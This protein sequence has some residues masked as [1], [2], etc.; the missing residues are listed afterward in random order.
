MKIIFEKKLFFEAKTKLQHLFT[1]LS[2]YDFQHQPGKELRML[3]RVRTKL[4]IP[5]R[6]F[7]EFIE[8]A[9]PENAVQFQSN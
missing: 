3:E 6:E 1:F 9:A 7:Y 4:N 8:M 2:E 5:R